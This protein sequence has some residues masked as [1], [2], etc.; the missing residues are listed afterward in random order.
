MRISK[1][2]PDDGNCFFHSLVHLGFGD[3]VRILRKSLGNMM[4]ILADTPGV[5]PNQPTSTL[6]ELF[7]N[8][9]EISA[10]YDPLTQSIRAYSYDMM[11][12]DLRT[13]GEWDRLPMN[14]IMQLISLLY[15][16]QFIITTSTSKQHPLHIAWDIDPGSSP[17]A[18]HTYSNQIYLAKLSEVHYMPLRHATTSSPPRISTRTTH[19]SGTK[20]D[21]DGTDGFETAIA[22][23]C[24]HEDVFGDLQLATNMHDSLRKY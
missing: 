6:R 8:F 5:L 18:G 20:R 11:C 15:D 9:N 4:H 1:H 21:Q 14:L 16:A 23:L 19:H 24:V 12:R 2:V 17:A 13:D 10:I 3:S 7:T 22:G